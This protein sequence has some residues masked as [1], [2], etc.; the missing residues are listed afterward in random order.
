MKYVVKIRTNNGTKNMV[1]VRSLKNRIS[2]AALCRALKS[3][4]GH[5]HTWG[6]SYGTFY[7]S[8]LSVSGTFE[9]CAFDDSLHKN[10]TSL[11]TN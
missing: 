5:S 7:N 9:V 11:T 4:T 6:N 1:I 8:T 10:V 2:D 3:M